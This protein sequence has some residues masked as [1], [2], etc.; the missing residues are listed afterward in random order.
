MSPEQTGTYSGA[1]V[2]TET[3]EGEDMRRTH[4]TLVDSVDWSLEF[5]THRGRSGTNDACLHGEHSRL[6]RCDTDPDQ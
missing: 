4:P 2:V 1:V 3:P 6:P 5:T